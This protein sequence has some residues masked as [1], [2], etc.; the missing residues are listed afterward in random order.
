M[1]KLNNVQLL[2]RMFFVIGKVATL[3]GRR[4][5]RGEMIARMRVHHPEVHNAARVAPM[6]PRS[7]RRQRI[8]ELR[9][10]GME[11]GRSKKDVRDSFFFRPVLGYIGPRSEEKHKDVIAAMRSMRDPVG[12]SP[13]KSAP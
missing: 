4:K 7:Q 12:P 6:A 2:G 5:L 13:D 3:T 10:M 11:A 9:Q 8:K 1:E